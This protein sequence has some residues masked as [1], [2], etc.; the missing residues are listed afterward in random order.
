M[1]NIP[2]D[3]QDFDDDDDKLGRRLSR[4]EYW[5]NLKLLMSDFTEVTGSKDHREYLVWLE[6]TYGFKPVET[7][8]GMMT[9]DLK[10]TD[11]KKY[12]VYVLK[13]GK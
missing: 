13:Y 3:F 6:N 4:W 10:I 9:D 11:E 8:D 1:V 5:N 2:K 12:M 7:S